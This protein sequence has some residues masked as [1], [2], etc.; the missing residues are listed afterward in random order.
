MLLIIIMF[1][2]VAFVALVYIMYS[3]SIFSLPKL[4]IFL[5]IFTTER[6]M[7]I[8]FELQQKK[9]SAHQRSSFLGAS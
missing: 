3:M 8:A 9:N 1:F 6:Q 2:V 7:M 4:S 5:L